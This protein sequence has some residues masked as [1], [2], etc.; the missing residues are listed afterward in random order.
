[1]IRFP[2]DGVRRF[3]FERVKKR[4]ATGTRMEQQGQMSLFSRPGAGIVVPLPTG[5]SAFDEALMLDERGDRRAA[6]AYRKAIEDGDCTADAY[7]NLGV[8]LTSGR[9]GAEA[10]DCF[11]NALKH[12][13]R[14]FES[15]Y[16][17]GNLYFENGELRPA[18]L[19]YE[20]A[21]GIDPDFPGVFFNLGIVS[22]MSEEFRA[23]LDALTR[24]KE[25]ATADEGH[26]ADE[27]VAGLRRSIDGQS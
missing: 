15:H 13:P 14:H 22:A 2:S 6:E 9:R 18:R 16:N 1:M 20:I 12:D 21:A 8:M 25:L 26:K 11:K 7:C 10:F 24:Y 27:L 23:A 19:H 17:V 5:M 3:G 4:R